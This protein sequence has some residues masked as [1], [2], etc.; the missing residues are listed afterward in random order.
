MEKITLVVPY[1]RNRGFLRRCLDS[2]KEQTYENFELIVKHGPGTWG[3]KFN[4]ALWEAQGTYIKFLFEDDWLPPDS[5]KLL[6][7]GIGDHPWICANAYNHEGR[8]MVIFKSRV[9]PLA[10]IAKKNTI[11]AGTTLYRVDMLREIGGVR[12]DLLTGE[13][14]E[15]HLRMMSK[16][17]I[18]GYIGKEVYCYQLWR[19]QKSRI[20]KKEKG[21]WRHDE[22]KKIQSLYTDKV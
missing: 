17:Y 14:Y 3:K 15:M 16:G 12:E 11:H 2:V 20:F 9:V 5:L 22:I 4:E 10:Q 7:E 21:E 19:G 6:A 8:H 13:E 1:D 18:P